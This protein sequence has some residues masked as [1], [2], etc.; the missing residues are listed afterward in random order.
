MANLFSALSSRFAQSSQFPEGQEQ[1]LE[2]NKAQ[3][4]IHWVYFHCAEFMFVSTIGAILFAVS[5]YY[6]SKELDKQLAEIKEA[7][8]EQLFLVKRI[9]QNPMLRLQVTAVANLDEPAPNSYVQAAANAY[10][11][12]KSRTRED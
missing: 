11:T 7:K 3:R 6:E 4:V 8:E 9:E 1:N 10:R 5:T 2:L 12:A